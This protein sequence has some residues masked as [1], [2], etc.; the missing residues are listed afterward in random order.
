MTGRS[1]RLAAYVLGMALATWLAAGAAAQGGKAPVASVDRNQITLQDT[2][3]LSLQVFQSPG[4]VPELRELRR[5][6]DILSNS[7]SI[8]HQIIN[9]LARYENTWVFSLAPKRA[10]ALQIPAISIA[11]QRTQPIE[12]GVSDGQTARPPAANP[13]R[14][15]VFVDRQDP[16]VQAQVLVTVRVLTRVQLHNAALQP[17]RLDD[18]VL[19]AVQDRRYLTDVD[20]VQ[21]L[22]LE[23]VFAVFPQSSGVSEV[24]SVLFTARVSRRAGSGIS[25]LRPGRAVTLRSPP[26]TLNVKPRPASSRS[27][28]WLPARSLEIVESWAPKP[29]RLV[30]GSPIT[31]KLRLVAD[32]ALGSQ[33]PPLM[34]TAAPGNFKAYPDRPQTHDK[35][36]GD[37]VRGWREESAALVAVDERPIDLPEIRIPWWNTVTDQGEVLVLPARVLQARRG[38]LAQI[39]P[40]D[41]A[42]AD[43]VA[44]GADAVTSATPWMLRLM[45][46]AGALG[47]ILA[48]WAHRRG[49][50]DGLGQRILRALRRGG[51]TELSER[52]AWRWLM[53]SCRSEDLD[54]L[55]HALLA[56]QA[57]RWPGS[58]PPSA[59]AALGHI[60]RLVDQALYGAGAA[61]KPWPGVAVAESLRGLR[62]A[63][64]TEAV[65]SARARHARDGLPALYADS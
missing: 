23:R 30:A 51:E 17:P 34:E 10:G 22:A 45:G 43:G 20:G 13:V 29:E 31:R 48:L 47:L 3:Q 40:A 44:S 27:A 8:S 6:F 35:L 2:I 24:P 49:L 54:A 59:S 21:H 9:G 1:R 12:V 55:R 63:A 64:Q 52:S 25:L 46:A 15:D 14:M 11:G 60:L 5:D 61:R 16:Y 4:A 32:G 50:L 65:L 62:R 26:I 19:T 33:L 36:S 57:L 56:W 58:V 41:S 38:L 28:F 39:P 42:A 18:A 7:Q 53:R 37:G